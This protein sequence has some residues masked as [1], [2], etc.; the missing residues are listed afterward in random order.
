MAI[1]KSKVVGGTGLNAGAS[2][3]YWVVKNAYLASDASS[4]EVHMSLYSSAGAFVS[5]DSP[6]WATELELSGK[7]NPLNKAA[8]VSLVQSK[9][10]TLPGDF[11]SGTIV[12]P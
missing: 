11:L 10:I 9:L 1:E 3:N 4:V 6:V 5:G 2:G 12:Q 8:I 7:D